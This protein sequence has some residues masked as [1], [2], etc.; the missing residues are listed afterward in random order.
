MRQGRTSWAQ[1]LGCSGSGR[2]PP[3]LPHLQISVYQSVGF[4]VIIVFSKGIDD[5]LSHLEYR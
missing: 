3:Y 2:T 5:L 1:L 4:K